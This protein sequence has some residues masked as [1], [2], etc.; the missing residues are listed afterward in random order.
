MKSI[1]DPESLGKNSNFY[2]SEEAWT[3]NIKDLVKGSVERYN[4]YLTSEVIE[5]KEI[6]KFRKPWIM[7]AL[8]LIDTSL[9][10]YQDVYY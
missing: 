6:P 4:F 8:T 9:F 3:E 10:V 5:G 1:Y 7:R 2:I